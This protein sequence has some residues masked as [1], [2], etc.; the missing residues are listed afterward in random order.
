MINCQINLAFW[1]MLKVALPR[2]FQ[3]DQISLQILHLA[4]LYNLESLLSESFSL[5][6]SAAHLCKVVR[7]KRAI[8]G[9]IVG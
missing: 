9:L 4:N 5:P 6:K 2:K 7:T 1:G 8:I 3:G